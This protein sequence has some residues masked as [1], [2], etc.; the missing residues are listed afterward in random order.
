MD[1]DTI[2]Q[3]G[4]AC[5]QKAVESNPSMMIPWY[6]MACYTYEKLDVSI[7]TDAYYDEMSRNMAIAWPNLTHRHKKLI[8]MTDLFKG[9]S[10][11][12]DMGTLPT[13]VT[14]AAKSFI[15]YATIASAS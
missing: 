2:S 7:L 6:L 14:D 3:Y 13:L 15:A 9:S 12:I 10:L 5:C 8:G 11:S 4:N 1:P